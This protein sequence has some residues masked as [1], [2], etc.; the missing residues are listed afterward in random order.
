[1]PSQEL[2]AERVALDRGPGEDS[3]S[4]PSDWN[5]PTL[6]DTL[7][8]RTELDGEFLTSTPAEASGFD[9]AGPD[10]LDRHVRHDAVRGAAHPTPLREEP[11]NR[12]VLDVTPA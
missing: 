1:M 8:L 12:S 11:P 5:A 4:T 3:T 2:L 10:P 9:A 7:L 6:F